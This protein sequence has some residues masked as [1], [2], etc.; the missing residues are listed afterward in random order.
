MKPS[1]DLEWIRAWVSA[2]L[3]HVACLAVLDTVVAQPAQE[4]SSLARE[5]TAARRSK[6]TI[7]AC[8]ADADS[9]SGPSV[10]IA[11]MSQNE[12]VWKACMFLEP[13]GTS[14]DVLKYV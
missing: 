7:L 5:A 12:S 9:S 13:K 1:P 10:T 11:G 14:G 3:R 4:P 2:T 8:T 6:V